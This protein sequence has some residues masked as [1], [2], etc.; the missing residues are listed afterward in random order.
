[1]SIG[2]LKEVYILTLLVWKLIYFLMDK[3]WYYYL[4]K[5]HYVWL[6]QK[7]TVNSIDS[8][9]YIYTENKKKVKVEA[10]DVFMHCLETHVFVLIL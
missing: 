8:Q 6:C 5:Y 7:L 9:K 2:I 1:M 10:V 4:Y 3:Y